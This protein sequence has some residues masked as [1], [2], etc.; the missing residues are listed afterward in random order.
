MSAAAR[1]RAA[2][3][4][5]RM[6]A[7]R[8]NGEEAQLEPANARQQNPGAPTTLGRPAGPVEP[9]GE[10]ASS[11]GEAEE[12]APAGEPSPGAPDYGQE[13]EVVYED[14]VTVECESDSEPEDGAAAYRAP[15]PSP[16]PAETEL[17][18]S[19]RTRRS[20]RR[21]AAENLPR[22]AGAWICIGE[23]VGQ[24]QELAPRVSAP[25]GAAASAHPRSP[26]RPRQRRRSTPREAHSPTAPAAASPSRAGAP[27]GTRN[28][29]LCI[30]EPVG[31]PQELVPM[32]WVPEGA[33]GSPPPRSPERPRQRQRPTP[34][35]AH[36]PAALATADPT[37]THTSS[38][39]LTDNPDNTQATSAFGAEAAPG[40]PRG[41][42]PA[43]PGVTS[44]ARRVRAPGPGSRPPEEAGYPRGSRP[45]PDPESRPAADGAA[46][47]EQQAR[48]QLA[49][50]R[51]QR[52]RAAAGEPNA[53][54]P[55]AAA[56]TE[57]D[58][59]G[60]GSAEDLNVYLQTLR[61]R[62]ASLEQHIQEMQE[63]A[64]PE[65][66]TA[67]RAGNGG[68]RDRSPVLAVPVVADYTAAP[69]TPA[70]AAHDRRPV[71]TGTAHNRR[72]DSLPPR[73]PPSPP[74][75][76]HAR[77]PRTSPPRVRARADSGGA[78]PQ[79]ED[80]P[81]G[82]PVASHEL[83][84]LNRAARVA[85]HCRFNG[86]PFEGLVPAEFRD[87]PP[88]ITVQRLALSLGFTAED[89]ADALKGAIDRKK[90]S[91]QLLLA[92]AGLARTA[93]QAA[94]DYQTMRD[95]CGAHLP[96]SHGSPPA[97]F[98]EA[99]G[100]L[101]E[102]FAIA[103]EI[104][105]APAGACDGSQE[106]D[107]AK[108]GRRRL[109]H[110]TPTSEHAQGAVPARHLDHLASKEC[111]RAEEEAA[112]SR[113]ERDAWQEAAR[114]VSAHGGAGWAV[115]FS[116]GM[117]LE[118]SADDGRVPGGILAA[119]EGLIEAIKDL[120]ISVCLGPSQRLRE[121]LEKQISKVING[122]IYGDF[123]LQSIVAVMGASPSLASC[124]EAGAVAGDPSMG[125]PGS[126]RDT[127]QT[128]MPKA[129]SRFSDLLLTV[130]NR[131][132]DSPR[133]PLEG[134]RLTELWH[135]ASGLP[136]E[137][138]KL[139]DGITEVVGSL[140]LIEVALLRLGR[141]MRE[142]R[143]A[144]GSQPVDFQGEVSQVISRELS[145]AADRQA[146]YSYVMAATGT[147]GPKPTDSTPANPLKRP[148]Q[149]QSPAAS[150]QQ[151]TGGEGPRKRRRGARAA[152]D[153]APPDK[154]G[155]ASRAASAPPGAEGNYA[156]RREEWMTFKPNSIAYT[157]GRRSGPDAKPNAVCAGE[158]LL[159]EHC[160]NV[161]P[162]E[163]PCIWH[164][165]FK[166]GCKK[167][168]DCQRCRFRQAQLTAGKATAPVP[169]GL[170]AKL[171]AACTPAIAEL[172]K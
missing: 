72:P 42:Q 81:S 167:G 156:P 25:G 43:E 66:A 137:T 62:A 165:I 138:R 155:G 76:A 30:G 130:H 128:D 162:N 31:P 9:P 68:S 45:V 2:A 99:A 123:D 7:A 15:A 1:G 10:P 135:G 157:V 107:K 134:L 59:V 100:R 75:L 85:H 37:R 33:P 117:S 160:P 133:P 159:A 19:P 90:P 170:L 127:I 8:L 118:R 71:P 141:A 126:M 169:A 172:L 140:R 110:V 147:R 36:A 28:N 32:A 4:A 69:P 47:A 60:D 16:A 38:V 78:E 120:I 61:R 3:S 55:G 41:A 64:Q 73:A 82:A 22:E 97:T 116:N 121:T 12:H 111:M 39:A 5:E 14:A 29:T 115:I 144:G 132:G 124:A 139:P 164:T 49:D 26:E 112:R 106:E 23:P 146:Q 152:A 20:R 53:G 21:T 58:P 77:A 103:A 86:T 46:A 35:A 51:P 57:G 13:C 150:T 67:P 114:V 125:R 166:G 163:R 70:D 119:R 158:Q 171:K 95:I 54:G 83:T 122:I 52:G 102:L 142:R 168:A 89:L 11:R 105:C 145:R 149:N 27:G 98:A 113:S 92:Q 88:A 154:H 109:Q 65:R 6:P 40:G 153:S 74:H 79:Q 96:A 24:P 148:Q 50:E 17:E 48:A 56:G 131:A 108:A 18:L 91:T 101:R 129:L 104:A 94:F 63:R 34:L 151:N 136:L 87:V 80:H 143:R 44:I 93:E 84:L 161:P